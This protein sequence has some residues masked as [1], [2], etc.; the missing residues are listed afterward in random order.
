MRTRARDKLLAD[1]VAGRFPLGPL[2]S[3]LATYPWDLDEPLIILERQH[4]ANILERYIDGELKA[5]EVAAW[6]DALEMRD[7]VGFRHEDD[8]LL[9]GMLSTLAT[10]EVHAPL[11]LIRAKGLLADIAR[12]PA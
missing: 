2:R 7:D 1:L 3:E 4:L 12:G 5:A 10:P 9:R 8:R 6:A 11:T